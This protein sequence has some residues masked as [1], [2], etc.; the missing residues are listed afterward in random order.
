MSRQNRA[1]P[2]TPTPPSGGATS[3]APG[4]PGPVIEQAQQYLEENIKAWMEPAAHHRTREDITPLHLEHPVAQAESHHVAA[5][6]HA[7]PRMAPPAPR[8]PARGA[9]P[10]TSPSSG[11]SE[12]SDGLFDPRGWRDDA[13][14]QFPHSLSFG[15]CSQHSLLQGTSY[16]TPCGNSPFGITQPS[17][18]AS[19][20]ARASQRLNLSA[21]KKKKS[22]EQSRFRT[23]FR[24]VIKTHPPPVPP[25]LLRTTGRKEVTGVGKVKVML[26]MCPSNEADSSYMTVDSRK[27]QVTLYDPTVCGQDTSGERL[28]GVAA[29]KMFAFDA[30]FSPDDNQAEVCS[31]SLCDVISSVVGGSDGCLFVYGNSKL[32]KTSTMI[33]N[34]ES[35]QDLGVIPCAIWWLFRAINEHKHRTGARFS[36]RVSAVEVCGKAEELRDLLADYAAGTEG[37][38]SAPGVYLRDD[39]TVFGSYLTNHS[40]LR[41]PTAERAAFLLDAAIAAR[42]QDN[43]EEAKNSHFLFTLHVYQYRVEKGERGGVSGGRSRLHL[44]DLGSCEKTNKSRDGSSGGCLSLSA[45]G[46]VILAL[47]NGQKHVPYKDS[48]LTQ[49]LREAMGSVMCRV[50]MIAHVSTTPSRYPETLAT[51]QLASRIH[52]LRRKKLKF[53]SSSELGPVGDEKGVCRPFVRIHAVGEDGVVKSGSSDQD[54]TSSS[55]QSC[56]TVIFV[57]AGRGNPLPGNICDR[58][59]SQTISPLA[60][61]A[62]NAST[63]TSTGT[64][65]KQSS[66]S[67]ASGFHPDKSSTASDTHPTGKEQKN[68]DH[69]SK[70]ALNEQIRTSNPINAISSPKKKIISSSPY[71]SPKHPKLSDSDSPKMSPKL[72]KYVM[73]DYTNDSRKGKG[74]SDSINKSSPSRTSKNNPESHQKGSPI[75]GNTATSSPQSQRKSKRSHK[76]EASQQQLLFQQQQAENALKLLMKE[77]KPTSDETWIDGPRFTKPKFDSRTLHQLQKEKWVDGPGMYGYMDVQKETMIRKWVEDH[78][79]VLKESETPGRKEVWIDFPPGSDEKK[80]N[81]ASPTFSGTDKS[82]KEAKLK[83]MDHSGSYESDKHHYAKPMPHPSKDGQRSKEDPVQKNLKPVKENK[84]GESAK[85]KVSFQYIVSDLDN[86]INGNLSELLGHSDGSTQSSSGSVDFNDNNSE[87]LNQGHN[88]LYDLNRCLSKSSVHLDDEDGCLLVS[89]SFGQNELVTMADSSIQV[90]E[91]D[92]FSSCGW[93][94]EMLDNHHLSDTDSYEGEHPL[95][96]LSAE[97]LNLASSFTDSR[98]VS[99]DFETLSVPE[100]WTP[101][102][103]EMDPDLTW[104]LLRG[105]SL[106]HHG[107]RTLHSRNVNSNEDSRSKNNL[108][109]SKLEKLANLRKMIEN[110][111]NNQERWKTPI[112]PQTLSSF[113]NSENRFPFVSKLHHSADSSLEELRE[114]D[115]NS[116]RSEPAE[117]DVENFEFQFN[118][119]P[120]NGLRLE[121]FYNKIQK[122]PLFPDCFPQFGKPTQVVPPNIKPQNNYTQIPVEELDALKLTQSSIKDSKDYS[123]LESKHRWSSPRSG[124]PSKERPKEQ[125]ESAAN[126]N[127]SHSSNE[128]LPIFE[129]CS[130]SSVRDSNQSAKVAPAVSTEK[131]HHSLTEIIQEQRCRVYS[132]GPSSSPVPFHTTKYFAQRAAKSKL[133]SEHTN[134][135]SK[136]TDATEIRHEY[137]ML[138]Q[139]QRKKGSPKLPPRGILGGNRKQSK[140]QQHVQCSYAANNSISEVSENGSPVITISSSEASSSKS[141]ILI[142]STSTPASPFNSTTSSP[143]C[144]DVVIGAESYS[145]LSTPA[146][147]T[148]I[149]PTI[150][151]SKESKWQA[152]QSSSGHGSDSSALST[153]D[154]KETKEL[155]GKLSKTPQFSGT[156]SGYES[157][158]RDS[159]GTPLSS[160]SQES[161]SEVGTKKESRGRKGTRKKIQGASKRSRSVPARPPATNSPTWQQQQQQPLQNPVTRQQIRGRLVRDLHDPTLW[162]S[163]EDV[164]CTSLLCCRLLDF[165]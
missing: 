110:S 24:E 160:S 83:T 28:A 42:T 156:S 99:V 17:A 20:F 124:T 75:P 10:V 137:I 120:M 53:A 115:V 66:K 5:H 92:I 152:R 133:V 7:S 91:E 123:V 32:G 150:F 26:R 134:H 22:T 165:Y 81:H 146:T 96:V 144:A 158:P 85:S 71:S 41:A 64:T 38:G 155:L 9:L 121:A 113:C 127:K 74:S 136:S 98:A 14:K 84:E 153:S 61:D 112:F 55:E 135:I 140:Q 102:N 40:E 87:D 161:G 105:G 15:G 89:D 141:H 118:V 109:A 54:Y 69:S 46:N 129:K 57:G 73:M 131:I 68:I 104:R 51:L 31:S 56:D 60:K 62:Q 103:R 106:P 67:H 50:A 159:E 111:S 33:G 18:A 162:K 49:L 27:K 125:L 119:K 6:P 132:E 130:P 147:T 45:L 1:V 65:K 77:P 72:G 58:R 101:D 47:F 90:T 88:S 154:L 63:G 76:Q 3:G 86:S 80:T 163:E 114:N 126:V 39:P 116:I 128:N 4:I 34:S 122:V 164:C 95:H 93:P 16:S 11:Y 148:V 19:F 151:K 107:S 13:W 142:R 157:M 145:Y 37:S 70:S 25:G 82:R 23:N 21:K 79:R 97:D 44:F 43:E 149:T 8:P 29:P 2:P 36:V 139:H 143:P 30:V 117:L 59:A 108:L 35:V 100:G 94:R 52:R 12:H 78:S 48:K 138:K